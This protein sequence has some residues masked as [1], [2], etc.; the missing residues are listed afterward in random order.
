M[1]PIAWLIVIFFVLCFLVLMV[2]A[3]VVLGY[4]RGDKKEPPR[5]TAQ[6]DK[7]VKVKTENEE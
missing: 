6:M 5:K 3:L 4:Y 2:Y 1:S 7:N